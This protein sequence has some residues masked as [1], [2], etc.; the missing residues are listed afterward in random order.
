MLWTLLHQRDGPGTLK[1]HHALRSRRRA[2]SA[3]TR[4]ADCISDAS[5][6]LSSGFG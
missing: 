6:N 1:R 3:A 4:H 5:A 2:A